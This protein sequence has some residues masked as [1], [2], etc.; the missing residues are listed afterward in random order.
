MMSHPYN[1]QNN[2]LLLPNNFYAILNF[3]YKIQLLSVPQVLVLNDCGIDQAG[4]PDDL[5]KKC[6]SVRELDLAQ[7]NLQNWNEVN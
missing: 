1:T 3:R 7:N 4:E 5:K 2:F 6:Y